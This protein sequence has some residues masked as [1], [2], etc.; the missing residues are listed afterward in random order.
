M[1]KNRIHQN[2][3]EQ[4]QVWVF[5]RGLARESGHWGEFIPEF[6]K[7]FPRDRL[8]CIDLPGTGNQRS[9]NSPRSLD[10]ILLK[11]RSQFQANFP[12][13]ARSK[14]I[15]LVAISLGAMVGMSW[16]NQF[17]EEIRLAV[18]INPSVGGLSPFYHRLR[19]GSLL[20]LVK[21]VLSR[22]GEGREAQILDLVSNHR[23]QKEKWK[24]EWTWL[25]QERPIPFRNI[26]NQMMAAARFRFPKQS[27]SQ[28]V[29]LLVG[30]RD[31]LVHPK[32]SERLH[33]RFGWD[34][35]R[36]PW[37]GHDLPLDDGA[38]VVKEIC[39]WYRLKSVEQVDDSPSNE[40]F[41]R[42]KG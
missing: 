38:W 29:L 31:R 2:E 20:P 13:S 8:M 19:L 10:E 11:V 1:T 15:N 9:Q 36:H 21:V 27:L 24:R 12:N 37:A 39:D 33:R 16:L 17:P 6:Q 4:E 23:N 30:M 3:N 7:A 41:T 26:L 34:I 18:F 35:M 32:C 5:L 25:A 22:K 14:R 28:P 40:N 42:D